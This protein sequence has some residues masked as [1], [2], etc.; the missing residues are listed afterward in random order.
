MCYSK[1]IFVLA[2]ALCFCPVSSQ[3]DWSFEGLVMPEKSLDLAMP[4]EGVVCNVL[5]KEGAAVRAGDAIAELESQEEK[6]QLIQAESVA[7]QMQ[8]DAEAASRL[9]AEKAAS[10][11]D[12]N[13]AVLAAE[14]ALAER[15]LLAIRLAERTLRAPCD[16]HI[17]RILKH[18]GE[19]VQRLEKT[20]EMVSLKRKIIAGYLPASAFGL[21]SVGMPV[22]VE[23]SAGALRGDLELVDPILDAGG[24]SFRIKALVADSENKLHVGSR[25]NVRVLAR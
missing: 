21:V 22:E 5:V 7:R 1:L 13:R 15:D 12:M 10:R 4:S 25:I 16:G 19:S 18:S 20:A 17:L 3:A 14:R 8:T 23:S 6:I 9:Y 24:A 2:F 11:D